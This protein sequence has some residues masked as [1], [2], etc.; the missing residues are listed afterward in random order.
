[1]VYIRSKKVNG[2]DYA[3]LVKSV[4]NTRKNT[5]NQQTIKYLGKAS[6]IKIGDIPKEYNNDPKILEFIS[7]YSN[8][9]QEK[10]SLITKIQE[11]IFKLLVGCN[12][13]GLVRIYEKHR[14]L[15]ELSSFYD[16]LM[17]PVMYN[18]GD[19]WEQGKL[20]VATEHVCSNMTNN[21]IKLINKRIDKATLNFKH[22]ILICTPEG[23]LHNLACNM[24]ESLLL[25]KGFKIYNISP[26]VP[27]DSI[28]SYVKKVEPDIILISV[29]LEE[30]ISAV[31]R[32]IN[33]IRSKFHIPMVVR[34]AATNQIPL[35][36]ISDV[37]IMQNGSLSELLKL[38]N[39]VFSNR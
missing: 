35:G 27:S 18:I 12:V 1:M 21:L 39:S 10:D 30:N 24:F 11:E 17:K 5:S 29:T 26:S 3:Y 14:R 22:K 23:E 9:R 20:D 25:S 4:W 7:F 31:Q 28:I 2:I 13:K 33:E 15:I 34:G 8:D 19:L 32:L 6:D 36:S 38:I 16:K 37:I